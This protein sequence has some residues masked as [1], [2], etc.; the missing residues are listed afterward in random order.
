MTDDVEAMIDH[1]RE[2]LRRHGIPSDDLVT[3]ATAEALL[4]D[5]AS[6][7][8]LPAASAVLATHQVAGPAAT[9]TAAGR[10]W[11]REAL[12][13]LTPSGLS[14]STKSGRAALDLSVPLDLP[15]FAGTD[16][17]SLSV[18]FGIVAGLS[19]AVDAQDGGALSAAVASATG[20]SLPRLVAALGEVCAAFS[21]R[22]ADF[23]ATQD[24]EE[25]QG[26]FLNRLR[27]LVA[28][29]LPQRRPF[30]ADAPETLRKLLSSRFD[31]AVSA[32]AQ[33]LLARDFRRTAGYHDYPTLFPLARGIS[34]RL[35]LFVGPTN[36]GKTHRALSVATAAPTARVLSPLRLLALEHFER[37]R[38]AGLPAGMV[39]GEEAIGEEGATHVAHTVETAPAPR[40]S[41]T[42]A[43]VDEVQMLADRDR[44]WAWT[45]AIV[46]MPAHHLVMTGSP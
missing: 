35:T 14:T 29:A 44:G 12:G 26:A 5:G 33:V 13:L 25:D 9:R 19:E 23:A 30:H 1:V 31:A 17:V 22:A 24:G 10:S 32:F 2:V 21:T 46:G 38:D 6:A 42:V 18:T 16:R 20:G 28:R 4:R 15:C 11:A 27:T 8:R 45:Q 34:R 41:A 36:S 3:E 43:V 40:R 37:L 7:R 39:T